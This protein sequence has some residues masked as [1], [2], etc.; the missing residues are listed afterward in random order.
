MDEKNK[1]IARTFNTKIRTSWVWLVL[2][3]TVGLTALFYFS[4]KPQVVVYESFTKALS[5]YRLQEANVMRLM[6]RVR[7]GF[8][9]D[10]VAVEAQSMTLREMA[11]SF[12]RDVDELRNHG[13]RVPSSETVQ[14]FEREVLSKVSTLRRYAR[15]RTEWFNSCAALEQMVA[16]LDD[17]NSRD[18]FREALHMARSG[19][20]V[21]AAESDLMALPDSVRLPMKKL[22]EENE[23]LTAAWN[24]FDN[25]MAAAYS[26]DM[27]RFF[28]EESLDEVSLK[29]KIPMAFYFLSL[30]LLLSTFFF[31]LYG[32]TSR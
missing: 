20:V 4:Q 6:D 32:R 29:S 25:D 18:K 1:S 7:V 13:E 16:H 12:A 23:E 31:A 10:T 3:I 15:R 24:V 30:V 11:V 9:A 2:A 22:F 21:Y 17:A 28:K 19:R 8:D 27:S 14:R 5:D 26:D